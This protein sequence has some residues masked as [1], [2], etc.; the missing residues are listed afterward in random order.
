M[1]EKKQ[2]PA[3]DW[4]SLQVQAGDVLGD[5]FWQEIAGILPPAGPR[6]DVYRTAAMVVV[7]VELPG[8]FSPEQIRL[9]LNGRQLNVEGELIRPYPVSEEQ[10]LQSERFFGSFRRSVTI[11]GPFLP[12][13]LKAQYAL[14]LLTVQLPLAP[15]EDK[16]T[17]PVEF[18]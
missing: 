8:L 2:R 11:P 13:E 9:T 6:M 7:I 12:Q 16:Q 3:T 5:E 10:M 4:K 14:G 18:V 17:I 15:E 1:S